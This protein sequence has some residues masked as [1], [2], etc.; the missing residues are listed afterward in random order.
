MSSSVHQVAYALLQRSSSSSPA[1]PPPQD[2]NYAPPGGP[3]PSLSLPSL[4]LFCHTPLFP[5]PAGSS[6]SPS[7]CLLP[8]TT[9]PTPSLPPS[10]SRASGAPGE[11]LILCLSPQDPGQSERGPQLRL[12]THTPPVSILPLPTRVAR[13]GSTRRQSSKTPHL[14]RMAQRP[15]TEM[16]KRQGQN[17]RQR[18][19]QME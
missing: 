13:R 12:G 2:T 15:K 19:I 14:P 8:T 6:P 10:A 17:Q 7:A 18:L 9:S 16:E 4:G 5:P 1:Q 3:Q 11:P